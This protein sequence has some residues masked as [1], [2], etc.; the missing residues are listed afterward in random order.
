MS[1][2]KS[3]ALPGIIGVLVFGLL[4]SCASPSSEQDMSSGATGEG[5]DFVLDGELIADEELMDAARDGNVSMASTFPPEM[6][7]VWLDVLTEHTGINVDVTRAVTS[8][9]VERIRSEHGGNQLGFDIVRISDPGAA[10]QLSDED[11][12][13]P[14]TTPF[15][16]QL[17]ADG[18]I[19]RDG[20]YYS[21][22]YHLMGFAYNSTL[23]ED[24]LETWE[25]IIRPELDGKIGIV[26]T[27]GSG[28]NIA[29]NDMLIER[30]GLDYLEDLADLSPVIYESTTVQT[31]ALSRGEISV[32]TLDLSQGLGLQEAGVPVEFVMPEMGV[33]ASY[34][35][36]GVTYNGIENPAAQVTLN[37]LLSKAGQTLIAETGLLS[38]R[39]D[40][41]DIE[42]PGGYRPPAPGDDQLAI[43]SNEDRAERQEDVV[44]TWNNLF[45]Y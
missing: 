27:A 10:D 35:P 40:L 42:L 12:L 30:I 36:L 21:G 34:A 43:F 32:A 19:L 22:W 20:A 38:S 2:K 7:A 3:K 31:E 28:V 24:D 11:I 45:T 6:E 14:T 25:D 17:E 4:T 23:I 1:A 5:G 18:A 29:M 15:D 8:Q 26:N 44:D 16:E 41:G 13:V 33:S 37:F 39:S 9:L